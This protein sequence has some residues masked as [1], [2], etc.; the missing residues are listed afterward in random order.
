MDFDSYA[1][2][3]FT[4]ECPCTGHCSTALGD[5]ICRGCGRT[6]DEITR[7]PQMT[8]EERIEINRRIFSG[9]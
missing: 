9:E 8:D 1:P 5:E 4:A 6:F 2:M 3:E 7:W